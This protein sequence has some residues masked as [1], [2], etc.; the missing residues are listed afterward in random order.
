[1][2]EIFSVNRGFTL[3]EVVIAIVLLGTF[4]LALLPVLG[5]SSIRIFNF[6]RDDK[7]V[8]V[9]SNLMET[10]YQ[11][12]IDTDQIDEK[13]WPDF[14][15]QQFYFNGQ[16]INVEYIDNCQEILNKTDKN[17]LRFCKIIKNGGYQL[18][19]LF[20]YNNGNE[21]ISLN[22]FVRD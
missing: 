9:A 22:S 20:F 4:V 12:I 7:A 16:N 19:V 6:G 21:Q 18:N 17:E 8:T 15:E 1:M 14:V 2:D 3:I 13:D 10:L 11:K 5:N